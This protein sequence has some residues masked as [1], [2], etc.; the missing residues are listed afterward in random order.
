M[1]NWL[2]GEHEIANFIRQG[3]LD[4][5]TTSQCSSSLTEWQPPFWKSRLNDEDISKHEL[6]TTDEKIFAALRFLKLYKAP[7]PDGLHVGFFQ[8][9]WPIV[10]PSVKTKVN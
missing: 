3:F 10:G 9:F 8:Q 5:F 6:P 4:L 2:N 7:G 1:G